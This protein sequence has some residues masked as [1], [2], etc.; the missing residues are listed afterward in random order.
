MEK[1]GDNDASFNVALAPSTVELNAAKDP[2]SD[3][4]FSTRLP[5]PKEHYWENAGDPTIGNKLQGKIVE[6]HGCEGE[7]KLNGEV[8]KCDEGFRVKE[9]LSTL[10]LLGSACETLLKDP[11]ST[12]QATFPCDVLVLF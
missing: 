5:A 6:G 7:V 4:A 11:K 1:S 12:L 9:D 2:N 10:E 3:D 8:L